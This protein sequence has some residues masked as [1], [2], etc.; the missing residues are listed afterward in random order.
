MHTHVH[1]QTQW[2]VVFG[3]LDYCLVKQSKQFEDVTSGSG[4]LWFPFCFLLFSWWTDYSIIKIIIT[5]S[6]SIAITVG[7]A[8]TNSSYLPSVWVWRHAIAETPLKSGGKRTTP[9][10]LEQTFAWSDIHPFK[11]K[12]TKKTLPTDTIKGTLSFRR[13]FVLPQ[14]KLKGGDCVFFSWG[15]M[16]R[17]ACNHKRGERDKEILTDPQCCLYLLYFLLHTHTHTHLVALT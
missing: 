2:I 17:L 8:C 6:P 14:R 13:V 7:S 1:T 12:E 9:D 15:D 5:C 16:L 3:Y 11:P 10:P 4:K